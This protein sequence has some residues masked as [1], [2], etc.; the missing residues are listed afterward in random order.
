M[1]TRTFVGGKNSGADFSSASLDCKALGAFFCNFPTPEPPPASRAPAYQM[2]WVRGFR[3]HTISGRGFN[4]FKALRRH[5]RA[6]LPSASRAAIPADETLDPSFVLSLAS[7]PG[8]PKSCA[9]PRGASEAR[10]APK[11]PYHEF[12][13]YE[14]KTPE[15]RSRPFQGRS[16]PR[17]GRPAK[18]SPADL[19][20]AN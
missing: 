19:P 12:C 9:H 4:L 14:R 18:R 11:T 10:R 6:V 17:T 15:N 7:F 13:S 5:F 1:A 3:G 2:L 8:G 16:R 20:S